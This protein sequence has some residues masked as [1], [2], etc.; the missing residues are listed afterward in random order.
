MLSVAILLREGHYMIRLQT[1][2]GLRISWAAEPAV[3]IWILTGA[4]GF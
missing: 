3:R 1:W 4:N 2:L